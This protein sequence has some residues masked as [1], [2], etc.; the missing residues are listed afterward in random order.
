[1]KVTKSQLKQMVREAVKGQL[2]KGKLNED[3]GFMSR[4][5]LLH[6]ASEAALKFEQEVIKTLGLADPDKMDVEKRKLYLE[7]MRRMEHSV[8][9]AVATAIIEL[10]RGGVPLHQEDEEELPETVNP[11]PGSKTAATP[12][13]A[14]VTPNNRNPGGIPG[15]GV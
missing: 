6:K 8:K 15:T 4:R 10:L 12:A 9:K 14:P 5:T 3:T 2:N 1:M 7:I 13:P 11:G